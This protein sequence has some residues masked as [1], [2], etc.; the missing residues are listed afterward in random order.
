MDCEDDDETYFLG[1]IA[2]LGAE[3]VDILHI[4]ADGRWDVEAWTVDYAGITR[5]VFRSRYIEVFSRLAG[6]PGQDDLSDES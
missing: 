1:S 6:D 2:A 5:V 3:S 4:C